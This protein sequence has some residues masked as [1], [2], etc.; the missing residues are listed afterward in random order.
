MIRWNVFLVVDFVFDLVNGVSCLDVER[1]R[2]AGRD[3]RGSC[4]PLRRRSTRCQ[5]DSSG[6]I[7]VEADT[8]CRVNGIERGT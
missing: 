4:M 7:Q 8:R 3:I 6:I 1:E 5:G 2:F